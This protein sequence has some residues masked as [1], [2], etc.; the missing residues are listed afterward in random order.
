MKDLNEPPA[1]LGK[2][3]HPNRTA[4]G[5]TRARVALERLRTLWINTGTRCNIT[6][7]N[8]YIES[9]PEN[10]ALAYFRADDLALYLAEARELAR[11]VEE[12][13]FTGGEPF[14]NPEILQMTRM[15]LAAGHRVLILTNA[16]R[17]MMR[18]RIRDGLVALNAEY[19]DQLTLR[20]SL[21][22]PD[23]TVHDSERGIGSFQ[24]TLEGMRW[25]SGAGITMHVAG[26]SLTGDSVDDTRAAFARLFAAEGF[27]TDAQD[28][29]QTVIFPEMDLR[30]EVPEI[31]SACWGILH[32]SPSDV[33]CA[34]SRMAV[35]RKGAER[36]VVLACT[37]L[38]HD[39]RFELGETLAEARGEVALN[40]PHCAKFCVLGGASCSA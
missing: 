2:F 5:E 24:I 10:D 8:C 35:L 21:D 17:P 30:V 13:G 37:L 18:P 29:A 9:S 34:T 38:A 20:V 32:K 4:T 40:H 7:A 39:E 25:I 28:P 12:I 23:P 26:R 16:M 6:C 31:T 36:P 3:T 1:N 33:M 15:A 19:P 27:A 11:P 14:M 22:H